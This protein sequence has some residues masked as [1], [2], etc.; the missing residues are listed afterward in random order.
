MLGAALGVLIV[1]VLG[2]LILSQRRLAPQETKPSTEVLEGAEEVTPMSTNTSFPT[3]SPRQ[4][5]TQT[6]SDVS[7]VLT[8]ELPADWT[9]TRNEGRKG[10]QLS[11]ITAQSPDFRFSK[12]TTTDGPFTPQRYEQGAVFSVHVVRGRNEV[13][14]EGARTTGLQNVGPITVGGITGTFRAGAGISTVVGRNLDAIVYNNGVNY[15]FLLSYN[16]DT[17]PQGETV[18][19]TILASVRF[20]SIT[21]PSPTSD[22]TPSLS[23]MSTASP[24]APSPSLYPRPNV[25]Q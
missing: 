19:R 3:A 2:L 24:G 22:Q 18:F 13:G 1:V 7:H 4:P 16:P 10:I 5:A 25:W 15:V 8:L 12:D 17:Y 9:L 6:I 20:T 14:E 21:I 11:F 23:N